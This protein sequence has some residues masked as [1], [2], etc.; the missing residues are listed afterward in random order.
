MAY[1]RRPNVFSEMVLDFI[2]LTDEG[3]PALIDLSGVLPL[4]R[5]FYTYYGTKTTPPCE[6]NTRWIIL[7]QYRTITRKVRI[8]E[9]K[10]RVKI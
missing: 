6:F 10:Q 1:V 4:N 3:V 9:S 5:E 7:K 8:K 2:I